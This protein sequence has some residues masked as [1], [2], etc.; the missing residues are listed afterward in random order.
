MRFDGQVRAKKHLGQHFLKDE[1]IAE[2]IAA[3]VPFEGVEKVLEIGPGMGVM[4]KYLLRNPSV[5]TW[6]I[7]IDEESVSYLQ[8]NYNQLSAR[9]LTGGFLEMESVKNLWRYTVRPNR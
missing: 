5:E 4:T 3:V 6:V 1:S 7:E 9:I 8:A 2:R